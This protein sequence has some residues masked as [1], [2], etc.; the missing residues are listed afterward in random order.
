MFGKGVS[1]DSLSPPRDRGQTV[2]T[3]YELP[4]YALATRPYPHHRE[5]WISTHLHFMHSAESLTATC[6]GPAYR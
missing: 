4:L 5:N 6:C 1:C 3:E 2:S